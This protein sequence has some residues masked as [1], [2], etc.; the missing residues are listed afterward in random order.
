MEQFKQPYLLLFRGV[1][2]A[3][4]LLEQQNCA[5]AKQLLIAAQQQAEEAYISYVPQPHEDT[6]L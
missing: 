1:T 2:E 6:E 4:A 5:A 3:L